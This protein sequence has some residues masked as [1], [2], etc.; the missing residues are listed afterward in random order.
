MLERAL[1][2]V[3]RFYMY[4]LMALVVIYFVR[5]YVF[6]YNRFFCRQRVSY[7]DIVDD[8]YPR[9][10][11]MIPMHNEE[12]V[13]R[14]I[15]EALL[16]CA[17]PHDRLQIIALN[18]HSTDNTHD[19]VEVYVHMSRTN[20]GKM[21]EITALH[22]NSGPRGKQNAINEA[23]PI[24]TGDIVLVF[25]ADYLPPVGIL[26][27]LA[28]CF[29]DPEVGAVMGR[30][31]PVNTHRNLLTRMQ[32]IERAGG[33]QVD[34]EA[35][36]NLG[37]VTQYGGTVGGFR[38]Q[39]MMDLGGFR[40]NVVA[41][42]TELT[43][44]LLLSGWKVAYA[45]RAEC[46]EEVPETWEV[47]AKQIRRWSRGHNQVMYS[48]FLP[49]LKTR[50]LSFW[51]KIDGLLLLGLYFLP[52]LFLGGLMAMAVLLFFGEA[53][54]I[55]GILPLFLSITYCSIGNFAP[56]YE[57]GIATLLDGS[58]NRILLLPFFFYYFMFSL[59]YTALGAMDAIVDVLSG[60]AVEWEKTVRF[61]EADP[62]ADIPKSMEGGV[63]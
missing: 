49:L 25:D 60:R 1:L 52:L 32:D 41:E 6:S 51:E 16:K 34:Q 2:L 42:D 19:I 59:W 10:T 21:P 11:I 40:P 63:A 3:L 55:G 24:A 54:F 20:H 29:K 17:Y 7:N 38:R 13:A 46:Y 44:R 8:D 61:R 53:I 56:F 4:M 12:K 62:Q 45:N 28:V 5:H 22:R 33:Y 23:L 9:L 57:L 58:S 30:V 35:R 26:R 15:F 18:D 14:N 39:L 36:Y 50:Y 43:Y 31:I 47:R 37:L 27:T 48:Y